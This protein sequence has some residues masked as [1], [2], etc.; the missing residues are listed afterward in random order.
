MKQLKDYAYFKPLLFR[1]VFPENSLNC[2][3][4]NFYI[5][6]GVDLACLYNDDHFYHYF[7]KGFLLFLRSSLE[8]IYLNRYVDE[9]FYSNLDKSSYYYKNLPT[10]YSSLL[11]ILNDMNMFILLEAKRTQENAEK[12]LDNQIPDK[13]DRNKYRTFH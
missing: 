5:K 2:S 7:V 8:K 4:E 9:K 6:F 3:K 10:L 13:I 12:N 1:S 11:T